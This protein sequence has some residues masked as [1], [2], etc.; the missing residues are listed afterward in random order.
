MEWD[1]V[2]GG[3]DEHDEEVNDVGG[4]ARSNWSRGGDAGGGQDGVDDA[5]GR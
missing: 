1:A 2:G 5:L 3:E 4:H